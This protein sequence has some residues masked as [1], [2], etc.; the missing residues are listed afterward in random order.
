MFGYY[1]VTDILIGVL[2]YDEKIIRNLRLHGEII[3]IEL[4]GC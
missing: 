4:F 2:N 3:F 1:Y